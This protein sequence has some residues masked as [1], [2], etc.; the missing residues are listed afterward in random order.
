MIFWQEGLAYNPANETWTS[1]PLPPFDQPRDFTSSVVIDNRVAVFGGCSPNAVADP[2]Y[3]DNC[4]ESGE[5]PHNTGA[6]YDPATQQWTP[7]TTA[8]VRGGPHHLA[9]EHAGRL[10][11][12]NIEAAP[13]ALASYDIASDTWETHPAPPLTTRHFPALT[14]TPDGL[15]LWGG[16]GPGSN[17]AL[18][19]SPTDRWVLIEVADKNA[20]SHHSAS[21]LESGTVYISASYNNPTP[22]LMELPATE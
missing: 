22:L 15:F 14:A 6:L 8:P 21:L 2:Q 10:Y 20:R 1:I 9:T 17:G 11:V 3:S 13:T 12:V 18:Y 16:T 5:R 4:R 19:Y 7:I